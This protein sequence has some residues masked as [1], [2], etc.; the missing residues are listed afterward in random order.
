MTMPIYEYVCEECD[1]RFER[2]V[3]N[4]QQEIACPKCASKK[5]SIQLSVFATANGSSKGSSAT[6]S[7]SFSGGEGSCCGGGCGCN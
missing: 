2:I 5:A 1:T 3:L 7:T 4:K 6:S